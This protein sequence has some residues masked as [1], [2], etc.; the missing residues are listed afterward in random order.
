M[1]KPICQQVNTINTSLMSK[2]DKVFIIFG[3]QAKTQELSVW[4]K[5]Q[6]ESSSQACHGSCPCFGCWAV[7]F[8]KQN[9]RFTT[10]SQFFL[11][12]ARENVQSKSPYLQK[13]KFGSEGIGER[14]STKQFNFNF[15]M[16]SWIHPEKSAKLLSEQSQ[17]TIKQHWTKICP[18]TTG[19]PANLTTARTG[20]VQSTQAEKWC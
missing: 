6:N 2:P 5:D 17:V 11:F 1:S 8:F 7:S 10:V 4:V 18:A 3:R 9:R 16:I 14:V 20:H 13:S 19:E 15:K 12:F